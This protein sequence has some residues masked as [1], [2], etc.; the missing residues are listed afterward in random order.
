MPRLSKA[1]KELIEKMVKERIFIEASLL[2][3]QEKPQLFT[4]EELALHSGLAKGTLYNYFSDKQAVIEFVANTIS[5]NILVDIKQIYQD[6]LPDYRLILQKFLQVFLSNMGH[7][8]YM[9]TAILAFSYENI[10]NGQRFSYESI[11]KTSMRP[12]MEAFFA[13]GIQAGAFKP[14]SA[15][16]LGVFFGS[17]IRGLNIA[18][19]LA[20]QDDVQQRAQME[21]DIEYLI[22]NAICLK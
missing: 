19:T 5:D 22:I 1:K 7:Y 20:S 11:P 8:R 17:T 14:V 9:N 12:Y 2:L 6:N 10:S 21:K 15:T 18:L 16:S 3:Q 4:M 13:E